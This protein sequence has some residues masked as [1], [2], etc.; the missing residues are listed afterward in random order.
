M[1]KSS[2]KS[3][4]EGRVIPVASATSRTGRSLVDPRAHDV[5]TAIVFL[6]DATT[7]NDV[8]QVIHGSHGNGRMTRNPSDAVHGPGRSRRG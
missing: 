8:L 7:G 6:D 5:A 2:F 3:A 4:A 1:S